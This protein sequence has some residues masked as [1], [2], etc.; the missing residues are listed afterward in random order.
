MRDLIPHVQALLVTYEQSKQAVADAW[1]AAASAG[2][3][4]TGL[5]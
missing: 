5:R 2:T 1:A 4:K 3:G